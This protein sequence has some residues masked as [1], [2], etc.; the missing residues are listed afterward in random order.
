MGAGNTVEC[1]RPARK[2]LRHLL[3]FMDHPRQH[4]SSALGSD[5]V[6]AKASCVP[7]RHLIAESGFAVNP[8]DD[9][10]VDCNGNLQQT[11]A[12]TLVASQNGTIRK[13]RHEEQQAIPH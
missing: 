6:S 7:V 1:S 11:M 9:L 5:V 3:S 8:M 4:D 12:F 10:P 2:V 13:A